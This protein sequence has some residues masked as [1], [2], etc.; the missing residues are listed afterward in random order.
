MSFGHSET[1]DGTNPIGGT[2]GT[3]VAGM[4]TFAAQVIDI[5]PDAIP[6]SS[7]AFLQVVVPVGEE[8]TLSGQ[9]NQGVSPSTE[10][11]ITI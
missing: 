11:S 5:N 7:Y 3:A 10:F 1:N 9:A 6:G 8:I 2:F 4:G